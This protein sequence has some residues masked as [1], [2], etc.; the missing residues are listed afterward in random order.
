MRERSWILWGGVCL[1]VLA[2][3]GL[4]GIVSVNAYQRVFLDLAVFRFMCFQEF[5]GVLAHRITI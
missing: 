4:L 5:P 1:T 2:A 3:L